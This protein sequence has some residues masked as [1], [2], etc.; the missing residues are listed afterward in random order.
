MN[1]KV[2]S[3]KMIFTFRALR[4]RSDGR[5]GLSISS[6]RLM[7]SLLASNLARSEKLWRWTVT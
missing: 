6:V 5:H 1:L 3:F 4:Q 7:P 2:R